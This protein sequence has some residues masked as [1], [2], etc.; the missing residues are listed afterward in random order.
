MI[1]RLAAAADVYS[2]INWT[3]MMLVQYL[4]DHFLV[5]GLAALVSGSVTSNLFLEYI[6]LRVENYGNAGSYVT[7]IV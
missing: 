3:G 2:Y 6:F 5:V 1:G 7:R 4:Q